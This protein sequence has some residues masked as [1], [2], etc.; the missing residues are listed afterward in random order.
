MATC[1]SLYV[2]H[3]NKES[4]GLCLNLNK[5]HQFRMNTYVTIH[6]TETIPFNAFR[7]YYL[8]IA[9]MRMFVYVSFGV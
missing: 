6:A 8:Y 4:P 1:Y 7:D 3:Y 5:P 9:P 2:K